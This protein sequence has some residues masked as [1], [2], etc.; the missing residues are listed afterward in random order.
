[1][2]GLMI[3]NLYDLKETIAADLF[4]GVDYPWQV[5]AEDRRI[6]FEIRSD[7]AERGI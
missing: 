1:M 6:Y 2:E 7:I 3:K 4:D 5:T